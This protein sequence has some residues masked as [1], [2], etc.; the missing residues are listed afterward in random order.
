MKEVCAICGEI[1]TSGASPCEYH[2]RR[3][4]AVCEECCEDCYNSE[5]F[6]CKEYDRRAKERE[7]E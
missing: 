6:P 7:G 1:I 3:G 2:A 5:P 4:E